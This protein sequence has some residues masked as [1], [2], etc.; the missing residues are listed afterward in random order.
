MKASYKV[1]RGKGG[2]KINISWTYTLLIDLEEIDPAYED[3]EITLE[4]DDKSYKQTLILGKDGEVID[5]RW[6]KLTFTK[7]IPGKTYT[8]IHDLKRTTAQKTWKVILFRSAPLEIK[9]LNKIQPVEEIL[10]E[11]EKEEMTSPL[12]K[13][14]KP[15][16]MPKWES[17]FGKKETN[18]G[19][20]KWGYPADGYDEDLW[21]NPERGHEG[22]KPRE[23]KQGIEEEEKIY[24]NL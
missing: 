5:N 16:E 20:E 9:H 4:S 12:W 21:L 6:L 11:T 8:C 14:E 24:Q 1:K 19:E 15:K 18:K 23:D 22:W 7:I 13:K 3:D 2:N 17:R 10:S